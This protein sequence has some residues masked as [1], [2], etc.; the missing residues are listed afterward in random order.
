M[1]VRLRRGV[2]VWVLALLWMAGQ[3]A[4]MA[5]GAARDHAPLLEGLDGDVLVVDS[6]NTLARRYAQQGIVL[7]YGFN[8]AE[9]ARS[10]EAALVL[11]P[12]C[13]MCAWALAWSLGPNIN[14]DMDPQDADR[15]H[16]AL[17]QARRHARHAPP[18][19]RALIAALSLRHPRAGELDEVRY[20][21]RMQALALR[22][23]ND[24]DVAV[25]AAEALMNLHPYDWW[26]LDGRP[27]PWT[28]RIE[29]LLQRAIVLRPGHPGA[30]HYWIHLQESSP[31]PGRARASA[32][33]LRDA[34]PGSGHLLHMPSHIDMRTGRFDAAI[35]A[36]QRSIEADAR[37]LAQVD[38]QSAYRVGYVAHN[39][40]FLWA[41]ASMAGRESLALQ[42]ATAAWPAACGPAGQDP[43]SAMA[44]HYAVLPYFT[45]VR[46]GRWQALLRDTLPP[47]GA[48]PYPQAIWHYAR[49][50]ALVR[51]G[52]LPD[53]RVELTQL[54]RLAADPALRRL[55]L[56]NI[57]ASERLL[58]IAELTL[59]ADLALA[60]DE[61]QVAV[62]RLREATAIE[63]ALA[64]DEPHLWLAPTRH[65][66][67]AALLA[68]GQP[69]QALRVY[70]E[71]LRHYP[72]N[73]WSLAG[74]SLAFAQLA[75]PPA[76]RQ[77]A[78]RAQA[79]FD[80]A[81][82]LPVGSRF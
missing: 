78:L 56:K 8:P 50:T 5:A 34:V 45:R 36:S 14:A 15:V 79:A 6:A 27:Q 66:L 41:A 3:A 18:V 7:V 57:N 51:T 28:L 24:A 80:R 54:Q 61:P 59:Q 71:D 10:L 62:A 25:L 21:E 16:G 72:D 9:A 49:G 64:Y 82:R 40:H 63:D 69:E 35:V 30:H 29:A 39:H 20:A 11:D 53:A 55:K 47:D 77:A 48:Q 37:Y 26:Q 31:Q 33:A 19:Q 75:N 70:T 38:A 81:D 42:A 68:A 74:L 23:P 43:G 2:S 22:Y 65:A 73:G 13:A 1:K 44:Q 58:R 17:A 60:D 4:A 76:A 12:R 52:R 32:D 46:F 67:G